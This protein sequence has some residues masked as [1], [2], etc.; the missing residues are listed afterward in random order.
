MT[1]VLELPFSLNKCWIFKL[2]VLALR[3]TLCC[4]KRVI[5]CISH[6]GRSP[7]PENKNQNTCI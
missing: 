4:V 6:S 2:N 7:P 1:A 5:K 3:G